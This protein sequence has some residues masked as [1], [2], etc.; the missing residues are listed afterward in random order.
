MQ[1]CLF[2]Q[3][4]QT[5]SCTPTKTE[6]NMHTYQCLW[7]V[8]QP[9]LQHL[10]SSLQVPPIHAPFHTGAVGVGPKVRVVLG[11]RCLQP[12]DGV[13]V[14]RWQCIVLN[15]M[16]RD[17]WVTWPSGRNASKSKFLIKSG[18]TA[19]LFQFSD[20]FVTIKRAFWLAL[21]FSF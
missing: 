12:Q 8:L 10:G 20:Q 17:V 15:D 19:R 18:Q 11:T 4:A 5:R 1:Y 16:P 21:L 13:N 7:V 3:H 9:S 2:S 6:S 14:A